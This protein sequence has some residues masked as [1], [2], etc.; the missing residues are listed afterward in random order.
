MQ[1]ARCQEQNCKALL[2]VKTCLNH[3]LGQLSD[4][5][6][7]LLDLQLVGVKSR[8]LYEAPVAQD[9]V[10]LSGL[11]DLTDV[12]Y[13]LRSLVTSEGE[14]PIWKILQVY[15]SSCEEHLWC[16]CNNCGKL[17]ESIFLA[18][19]EL[20]IQ[21]PM[22]ACLPVLRGKRRCRRLDP[23]LRSALAKIP[24]RGVGKLQNVHKRLWKGVLKDSKSLRR[25]ARVDEVA[26]YLRGTR[27][28]ASRIPGDSAS[29]WCAMDAGNV[30][31][32]GVETLFCVLQIGE[33]CGAPLPRPTLFAAPQDS[34]LA[35]LLM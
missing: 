1:P 27:K 30:G 8:R 25:R 4:S 31:D 18:K 12:P 34:L 24:A 23:A 28:A 7:E 3:I 15:E 13:S 17:L 19:P 32:E 29:L 20:S 11:P 10:D 21:D 9:R 16:I 6:T 14:V 5:E 26:R 35:V 22:E 33:G 2:T